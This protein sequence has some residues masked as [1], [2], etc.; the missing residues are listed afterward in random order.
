MIKYLS[1]I[2]SN[3]IQRTTNVR[4]PDYRFYGGRGI[5]VCDRWR[6]KGGTKRFRDDII[7]YLGHRPEGLRPSGLSAYHLDRVD[8]SSGYA[9]ENLRWATVCLSEKNKR[10]PRRTEKIPTIPAAAMFTNS[11]TYTVG[12]I[13]GS[14]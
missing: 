12:G 14:R 2:H 13:N 11:S 7:A 9:I 8:N 10:P 1:T 4:H 3:M 6:G 5:V